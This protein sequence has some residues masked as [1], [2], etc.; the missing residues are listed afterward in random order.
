MGGLSGRG[1]PSEA[2]TFLLLS[3]LYLSPR[4]S[5]QLAALGWKSRGGAF[6]APEFNEFLIDS[7]SFF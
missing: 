1:L 5:V 3:F 4:F 6:F 7:L 2:S